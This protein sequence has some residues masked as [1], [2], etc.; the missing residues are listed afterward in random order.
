MT[1]SNTNDGISGIERMLLKLDEDNTLS[2]DE[3]VSIFTYWGLGK[4]IIKALPRFAFS[5]PREITVKEAPPD[6][7][8]RFN[9]MS[10]KMRQD[11]IVRRAVT[12]ARIFG[13]GGIALNHEKIPI[14]KDLTYK[15]L[16]SGECA[17]VALDP[18]NL[19]GTYINQLPYSLRFMRPD[20]IHITGHV[21]GS[22]RATIIQNGDLVY[23]KFNPSTFTFGGVSVYQNM[24]PLIKSWVRGTISLRRMATKAS[25]IVFSGKDDDRMNGLKMT[26]A[27]IALQKIVDMENTGAT[28]IGKDSNVQFF[29]LTGVAEVDTILKAIERE[30]MMA[31]ED[32]PAPLLLDTALSTGMA[33]GSSDLK[34]IIMAVN[35]FREEMVSPLY[36]F[37]DPYI[38]KLAWTDEY[39]K[40]VVQADPK[41]YRGM[42][43]ESIRDMWEKS[44]SY[45]WGN[46]YPEPEKEIQETNG[47]KLD[48]LIKAQSLGANPEDIQAEVHEAGI[49]KNRID[50]DQPV[51]PPEEITPTETV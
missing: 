37:T 49:F 25:S 28:Q 35:N 22:R 30:I 21:C 10:K 24:I 15:T 47:L 18:L 48:N 13:M 46:L 3:C 14:E 23:L 40:S 8:E 1:D 17:F 38:M 19:S 44:F 5:V 2:R 42:V 51:K 33:E 6:A 43:P 16:H 32:T 39:I 34:T 7:V 27:Q 4:R 12:Y 20:G 41:K 36:S 45:E 29:N 26:A 11:M 9:K 31:L 50:L